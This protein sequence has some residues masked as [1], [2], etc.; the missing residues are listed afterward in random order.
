MTHPTSPRAFTGVTCQEQSPASAC[1]VPVS[2]ESRGTQQ[3]SLNQPFGSPASEM[4]RSVSHQ[5]ELGA[6]GPHT[7]L[8]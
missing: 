1:N 2:G 6:T 5:V 3:N 8:L 4:S 7:D